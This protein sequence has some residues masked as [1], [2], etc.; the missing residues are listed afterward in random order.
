MNHPVAQNYPVTAQGDT[1]YVQDPSD[2]RIWDNKVVVVKKGH[3]DLKKSNL[4]ILLPNK[5]RGQGHG[6]V[7]ACH[8]FEPSIAEDPPCR[9]CR[10]TLNPSRLKPVGVMR[11]LTIVLVS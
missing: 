6:L 10:C 5:P 9:G 1:A 2:I 8:E 11:K 7:V 4:G 3:F